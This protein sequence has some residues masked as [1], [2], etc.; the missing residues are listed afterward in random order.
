[1]HHSLALLMH[2]EMHKGQMKQLSFSICDLM[3]LVSQRGFDG[4]SK[5][6]TS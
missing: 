3:W 5:T 1:M 2:K 4:Y 6:C